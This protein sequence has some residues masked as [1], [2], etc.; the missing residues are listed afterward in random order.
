MP[1]KHLLTADAKDPFTNFLSLPSKEQSQMT[2]DT[3][4]SEDLTF[5]V[6][7]LNDARE[8]QGIFQEIQLMSTQLGSS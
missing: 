1:L 4:A 2:S 5:Q 6:H 3:N 7:S 8:K